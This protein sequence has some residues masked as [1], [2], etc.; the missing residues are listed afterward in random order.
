ML[1][2]VLLNQIIIM[3]KKRSKSNLK[4]II[5]LIKDGLENMNKKNQKFMIEIDKYRGFKSADKAVTETL[6]RSFK[7]MNE[8]LK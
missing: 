6:K 3:Q 8:A 7:M 5:R 2:E 1:I 4:M